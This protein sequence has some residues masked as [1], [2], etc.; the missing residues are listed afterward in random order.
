MAN[1][2]LK[3]VL[4][5]KQEN[6]HND[7]SPVVTEFLGHSLVVANGP[8]WKMQRKTLQPAFKSE[9]IREM[10]PIFKKNISTLVEKFN[11]SAKSGEYVDGFTTVKQMNFDIS[12][13]KSFY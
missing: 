1:Q 11:K 6:Y 3:H 13:H 8:E 9:Y 7:A 12:N 10:L 4:F 2:Q 5:L